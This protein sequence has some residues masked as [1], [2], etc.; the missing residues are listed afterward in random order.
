MH[1]VRITVKKTRA[2]AFW[3]N[4]SDRGAQGVTPDAWPDLVIAGVQPDA[5]FVALQ[6]AWVS[7]LI[8][9]QNETHLK[10][11]SVLYERNEIGVYTENV[12]IRDECWV[13]SLRQEHAR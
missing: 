6:P 3:S 5:W 1:E 8:S 10:K 2:D 12:S 7:R 11:S 4:L 9:I 13:V